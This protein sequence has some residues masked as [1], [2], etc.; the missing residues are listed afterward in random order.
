M[1]WRKREER[2]PSTTGWQLRLLVKDGIWGTKSIRV[3]FVITIT[4]RS[5][6]GT[7]RMKLH[8]KDHANTPTAPII[9][10]VLN[11]YQK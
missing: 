3:G 7:A 2:H 10:T 5:S 6:M 11:E 9:N 1:G 8:V 4:Y